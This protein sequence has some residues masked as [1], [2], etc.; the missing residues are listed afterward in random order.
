MGKDSLFTRL[1]LVESLLS[2]FSEGQVV[3]EHGGI[4]KVEVG[5][6]ACRLEDVV[7]LGPRQRPGIAS[8]NEVE[9]VESV[10]RR[11]RLV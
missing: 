8:G 7:G 10:R 11:A 6:D 5:V 2:H 9:G 4:S 1:V 3:T